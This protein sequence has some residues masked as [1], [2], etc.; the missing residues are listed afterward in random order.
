MQAPRSPSQTAVARRGLQRS[1]GRIDCLHLAL[2]STI[3]ESD[4]KKG[5]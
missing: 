3:D 5:G 1:D 4:F 2:L